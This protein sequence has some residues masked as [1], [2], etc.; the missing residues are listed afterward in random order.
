MALKESAYIVI[1]KRKIM[2]ETQYITDWSNHGKLAQEF[3]ERYYPKTTAIEE[4]AS[5]QD[6]LEKWNAFIDKDALKKSLQKYS[7]FAGD[8]LILKDNSYKSIAKA[9]S[10]AS[11]L[12]NMNKS[13]IPEIC[14]TLDK[15]RDLHF[16]VEHNIDIDIH[17]AVKKNYTLMITVINEVRLLLEDNQMGMGVGSVHEVKR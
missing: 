16:F 15:L 4:S 9:F 3:R 13:L 7:E 11:L 14:A 5:E 12:L 8:K 2:T 17:D 6:F 10:Q 1:K